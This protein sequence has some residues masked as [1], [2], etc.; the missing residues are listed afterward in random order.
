MT[1]I[2][3]A[4]AVCAAING[5]ELHTPYIVDEIISASGET[6]FKAD[7]SPVRRVISAES[8]AY[9]RQILQ[10]VVDNGTGKNAKLANYTVGGKRERRRNTTNTAAYPREIISVHS[11]DS[12]PQ[13][14]PAISASSLLMSLV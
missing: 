3:L 12:L 9:V 5:G 1:P 2:Q 7:T 8:S 14:N 13:T 11:S 4:S 6:V 10:S